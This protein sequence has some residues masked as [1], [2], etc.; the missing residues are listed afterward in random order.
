M[1]EPDVG[2]IERREIQDHVRKVLRDLGNPEPPL[3]LPDVRKLL[4]LD[5]KY[6]DGSDA[7]L[8]AEVSHRVKLL[9]KK[10]LP[11]A[12]K[13]V[14]DVI[15]RSKLLAFWVPESKRVLIDSSVPKPKH[16]WIEGHEI[17]HSIAPW[18]RDFL[19]GDDKETLDPS[20]RAMLEAEAN[21][22]AG[23][24]LFLQDRFANEA[25]DVA[26][27]IESVKALASRYNNSITSTL[28]RL[29]EE[30][31]P[32]K[33]VFGMIS[34][35]PNDP[36]IG[37]HDGASPWRYFIRSGAFRTQ[38][39]NVKPAEVYRLVAHHASYR[40]RGPVLE[41]HDFLTDIAGE[42]WEF[43]IEGFSNSHALLTLGCALRKRSTIVVAPR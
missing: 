36:N 34:V 27:S 41:T 26:P 9:T 23:Q 11:D 29:V 39:S 8:L 7:G 6:Y 2:E 15:A 10:T 33:P 13:H 37:A 42:A 3:S 43:T 30:R 38:F 31:D 35:H 5:L 16:R 14:R 24:L 19:L 40:K 17:T 12:V 22:G 20:C 32:S 28:W 25:R 18:H 4:H 1:S 21:F